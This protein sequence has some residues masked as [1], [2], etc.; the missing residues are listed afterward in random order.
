MAH[1]HTFL[2]I[3]L[4]RPWGDLYLNY[5]DR[6]HLSHGQIN[7]DYNHREPLNTYRMCTA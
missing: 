3:I 4:I 1:T 7:I 5:R 6:V 2:G